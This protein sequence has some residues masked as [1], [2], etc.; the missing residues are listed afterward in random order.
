LIRTTGDRDMFIANCRRLGS[1]RSRVAHTVLATSGDRLA[2]V[3][4]RWTA[5]E[6]VPAFEAEHLAVW[7]V[8]TDGRIVAAISFDVDDRRGASAEMFER[9]VHGDGARWTPAAAIEFGRAVRDHDVARAR[10][11]LPDSFFFH[12]HRRTG[13]GLIESAEDY[14]GYLAALFEQSPDAIIESLYSVATGEHG[15]LSVGHTFGTWAE[16]GEFESVFVQLWFYQDERL[17]G[18]E[19]FEL[20][21]LDV[22]RGHFDERCANPA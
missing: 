4:L 21:D 14:I 19:L 8:D 15:V 16:G 11:A 20:E 9:Y 7:E 12:D 3:H 10:G 1:T 22:A 17:V 6:G 2:L 13:A 18:A 5:A